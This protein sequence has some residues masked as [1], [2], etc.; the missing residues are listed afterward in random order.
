MAA[1]KPGTTATTVGRCCAASA[2]SPGG[3][4]GSGLRIVVAPTE[5]GNVMLLPRPYAKNSFG[6][7][8]NRSSG[9]ARSTV[10]PIVCAVA[11]G[12]YCRCITPF[13]TP[14][15]PEEYSQNAGESSVVG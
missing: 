7:D 14:V 10:S 1:T 2:A 3:L 9:R 11:S 4:E 6:T 15:V 5:N 12:A 8:R 13:D